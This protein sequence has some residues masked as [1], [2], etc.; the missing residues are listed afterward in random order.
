MPGMG[1]K[2]SNQKISGDARRMK[3]SMRAVDRLAYYRLAIHDFN[4]VVETNM[5]G[6][7]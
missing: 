1:I 5:R 6:I 3:K 4:R 2:Y 7:K